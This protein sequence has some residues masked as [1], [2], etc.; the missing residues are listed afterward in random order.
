MTQPRRKGK[1]RRIL[2]VISVIKKR[3]S[4]SGKKSEKK[5]K[6]IVKENKKLS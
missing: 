1:E 4:E 2:E 6:L 3:E 5:M